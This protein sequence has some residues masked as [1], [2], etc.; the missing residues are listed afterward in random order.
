LGE[1]E[2][3]KP[4]LSIM[5]SADHVESAISVSKHSKA[6]KTMLS[7]AKDLLRKVGIILKF[8]RSQERQSGVAVEALGEAVG[9]NRGKNPRDKFI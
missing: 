6:S 2:K 5:E 1:G 8:P 4:S 7:K 3:E 9:R